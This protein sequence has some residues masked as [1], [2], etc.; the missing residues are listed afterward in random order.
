MD[1]VLSSLWDAS[2]GRDHFHIFFSVVA[3]DGPLS[4]S[5]SL[6]TQGYILEKILLFLLLVRLCIYI[7]SCQTT[8]TCHKYLN[9]LGICKLKFGD[10]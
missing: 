9:T 10:C 7:Y 5:C 8:T 3:L 1:L 2:G 4:F 6:L